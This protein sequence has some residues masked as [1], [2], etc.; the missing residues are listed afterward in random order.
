MNTGLLLRTKI[1]IPPTRP[2]FVRRPRL[3]ARINEGVKGLLTLLCAP[4]GFGKTQL[5]AEWAAESP[6]PIA[7]LTLSA[8]DNDYVRF[9][10]YLSS[11]FQEVEPR[12]SEAILDYLQAA[13]SSRLEMATLLINEVSAIPKHFVLVVDEHQVL[14]NSSIIADLNFLLNNLPPNLHLVIASRS[15][16]SLDLANLRARG[17]VTEIGADE[18]RLTHEEVMQF[19]HQTMR[20][21]LPPETIRAL[22]EST[23]GWVIGL[24]LAALSL[25]NRSDESQ[26]L[27]GFKG[28]AH[29]LVDF[30]A[31]EV[32]NR[33][34]EEVRQ[35]LLRCSILD[36]LSGSLCEAVTELDAVTGYGTRM[37]DQ[38]EDL[39]LFVT[40]LDEQHQW[41]RFHNL[42][43]EFL[44]HM[45]TE[46][47]AIEIPLLHKRAATWF[48][49][50]GNFDEAFK[51]G[52]ATGDM[53][54]ALTLIDRKLETLLESGE[55]AT[56]TYWT[57]K[58]PREHL[59]RRPRLALA[60]AWG[61]VATH[62]LDEARFW[63]D[64]VQRT[65]DVHG[66]E[67]N[68]PTLTYPGDSLPQ[69]SA[70]E[71]ALVRSLLALITG[72][73]QQAAEYSSVAVSYLKERNPF[74]KSFLSLEESMTCIF[75]GDTSRAIEALS[76]TVAFARRANNLFVLIVATCQLA[77]MHMLQGR[78]SQA[79]VTLQKARL[80]AVRSD[81][82]PLG[83][84]GI[85]DNGLGEILRERNQLEQAKEHLE[86]GRR[87]SQTAWWVSS[88]EGT[89]SLARLLQSQGDLSAVQSLLEEAFRL[90][91]S[92]DSSQWDAISV[93]ATAVRLALQ[94][95][96]LP[97][98]RRWWEQSRLR[99][100][101]P[102]V[103]LEN[104][105]YHV[106]EY[107]LLTEARYDLAVG[108]NTGDTQLLNQTLERLQSILPKAEQ[109][110]R[111]T[112]QIE[113]LVLRAM[114][115]YALCKGDQA[116]QTLLKALAL[117][118]PEDYRR[119]YLDEGRVMAELLARCRVEQQQSGAYYPSLQYIESLLEVSRQ[120]IGIRTPTAKSAAGAAAKTQDDFTIFL[121]A[122]ELE[123]LS[124]IAA[125]KSN[126]EIATQLYLALNTVKRH[127]SNIYDKLEVKKR[128]EAV[129]K[130]RQLGLI[131]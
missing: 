59:H 89:I 121:S 51:H 24:Q 33:Q 32:L 45:L 106:F 123:V 109:F 126:E 131:P 1:S 29:Y 65:L 44:R 120:E 12:L 122:R 30:L 61:L 34:A 23:E 16:Q 56:L 43:A 25:R 18:L 42:V 124:L 108:Q 81:E 58:L 50:H 107:L 111:V 88:L 4:A 130:A 64:D 63:L 69:P 14:G 105:P 86:H 49:Q 85:I 31:R 48:E 82:R 60:Y 2:G 11:A 75:S 91:L 26:P 27:R 37:L 3:T 119:I 54:W 104:Y 72:D 110:K 10:R 76:E 129:A 92:E 116:V 115:E 20:L 127:A 78:L 112:S 94:R 77:E 87:L 100:F 113:I 53:D 9:F 93:A 21:Q 97:A 47:H 62:R 117:G 68:Q 96:D 35:F 99:D 73:F 7:W 128:T 79:F 98:A 39:N 52:L 67:P 80:L 118:E 55:V 125:G 8:E 46:T 22:E 40:P 6:D 28:D 84:A 90:S 19:F 15:E 13:E 74:I 36:V 95:G 57:N 5:L 71:L 17:Q 83:L 101:Q 66:K 41:F 102:D 70:G 38:L 103:S 114:V